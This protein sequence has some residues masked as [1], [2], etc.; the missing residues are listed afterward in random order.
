MKTKKP[1]QTV[2][3]C[4]TAALLFGIAACTGSIEPQATPE[5]AVDV[6]AIPIDA[7]TDLPTD[8]P[9]DVPTDAPTAAP[10]AAPERPDDAWFVEEAWKAA[11]R[12][13]E[14]H[15]M[16]YD[17]DTA[18]ITSY[19][20]TNYA[21][22]SFRESENGQGLTLRF[23]TDETG[24]YKLNMDFSSPLEPKHDTAEFEAWK[25]NIDIFRSG[26]GSESGYLYN[27]VIVT[28]E[29]LL[30]SG[31]TA[32]EGEAFFNTV[33]SIFQSKLLEHLRSAP[34]GSPAY[35]YEVRPVYCTAD[36]E[37]PG[38]LHLRFVMRVADPAGFF[39]CYDCIPM[40]DDGSDDPQLFGWFTYSG[41]VTLERTAEGNWT[42]S[43]ALNEG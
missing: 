38:V 3:L 1:I 10:S 29:E 42:G 21:L 37:T 36:R 12:I 17:R 35:C 4:M 30:E 40:F 41:S 26:D 18:E 23:E 9:T 8:L 14:V 16:H 7:S 15:Q 2:C 13:A 20:N 25:A 22:V 5:P 32:T 27:S 11:E 43:A 28:A 33:G 31:C 24:E 19:L 39:D 6:T 34:E